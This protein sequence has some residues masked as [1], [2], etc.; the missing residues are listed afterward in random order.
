[1]A[2]SDG[3]KALYA[4]MIV[5]VVLSP[6][7]ER[8]E[9]KDL[10]ASQTLRAAFTKVDSQLPGFT[11]DF[12]S[13]L[14]RKA[15]LHDK[16]D[17]SETLLKLGGSTESEDLRITRPENTFQELSRCAATLKK[18]LS[19][20]PEQIY[21]RKQ[22]LETIKEIASAI[23]LLLDAVN[24]VISEVPTSENGSKQILEDRKREFV[25]YSKKFSNTL[26]EF[27]RDT[28]QNHNV[29]LSANYLTYQTNVIL[30]TVKQ[31]C[32]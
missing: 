14:L 1:M 12:A 5:D 13:G 26:K 9:K 30:R 7:F 15:D 31:E 24:R 27:F 2:H 25:R 20:I 19:R 3:N 16:L 22:F 4:K 8:L 6:L 21:D 23:K 11:F 28:N 10:A 29:F 32:S 18:I 17:V